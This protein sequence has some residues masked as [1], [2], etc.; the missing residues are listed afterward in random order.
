M[1]IHHLSNRLAQTATYLSQFLPCVVTVLWIFDF[2]NF[3]SVIEGRML[4]QK[5]QPDDVC[6]HAC[7]SKSSLMIVG[8][9]SLAGR[10]REW[11]NGCR[12]R[13][14]S[15]STSRRPWRALPRLR[16]TFQASGFEFLA[17]PTGEI[18]LSIHHS[19]SLF[20][21]VDSNLLTS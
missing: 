13:C 6:G 15:T 19:I 12:R 3:F 14:R 10:W 9:I 11:G 8:D 7:Q 20:S 5:A 2:F 1:A 18:L 16:P 21:S 17:R 4:P